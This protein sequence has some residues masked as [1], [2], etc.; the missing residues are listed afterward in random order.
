VDGKQL[1]DQRKA[2]IVPIGAFVVSMI[3]WYI[4]SVQLGWGKAAAEHDPTSIWAYALKIWMIALALGLPVWVGF[5]RAYLISAFRRAFTSVW[6]PI[7]ISA[8]MYGLFH[9]SVYPAMQENPFVFYVPFFTV[10]GLFFGW[11]YQKSGS[12]LV[13]WICH[14]VSVLP[15]VPALIAQT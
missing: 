5:G 13:T 15:V 11:L 9:L 8:V 14:W 6:P 7:L 10:L 1:N 12:F 3:V 4:C 2:L